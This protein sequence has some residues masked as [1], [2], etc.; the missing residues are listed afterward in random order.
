M[1]SLIGDIFTFFANN[2]RVL[3]L[4][5]SIA[6]MI[7][8]ALYLFFPRR[9]KRV[10]EECPLLLFRIV[11]GLMLMLGLL[12]IYLYIEILRPLFM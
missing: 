2:A 6:V 3:F 12:L 10:V 7:E 5:I 9:L 11:G 4:V 1:K 8:G